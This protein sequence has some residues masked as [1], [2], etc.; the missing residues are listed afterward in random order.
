MR[1]LAFLAVLQN[2]TAGAYIAAC[3]DGN[4]SAVEWLFGAI[5]ALTSFLFSCYVV[6]EGK[7]GPA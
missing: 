1:T 7:S 3:A 6:I 2:L 4:A 5:L